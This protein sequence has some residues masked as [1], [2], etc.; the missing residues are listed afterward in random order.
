MMKTN[1][2]VVNMEL[3]MVLTLSKTIDQKMEPM[4]P[5]NDANRN[6]EK[7]CPKMIP[8]RIS[9]YLYDSKIANVTTM[10]KIALNADSRISMVLLFSPMLICFTN[11]IATADEE[12][13]KAAPSIKL[14][15]GFMPKTSHPNNPMATKVKMK[16]TIVKVTVS[17]MESANVLNDNSVPLSNSRITSVSCPNTL[18]M[19]LS[20]SAST[21]FNNGPMMMPIN[22]SN[23]T[24][25]ILF[26]LK[27]SANQCAANTNVPNVK[28]SKAGSIAIF[29][30]RYKKTTDNRQRTT[31]F[32]HKKRGLKMSP[33]EIFDFL[34]Y[35]PL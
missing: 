28:M 22:I 31:D 10:H 17:L 29:L 18:P 1:A 4:T 15:P 23:N 2:G 9:P 24:S 27:I 26:L 14:I 13:P 32:F 3:L 6:E 11:G 16:F 12:P 25:G 30:Q 19:V 7:T 8:T 5:M 21:S 34:Y 35:S 20:F 33:L